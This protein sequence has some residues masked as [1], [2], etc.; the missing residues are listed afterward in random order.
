ML[1]TFYITNDDKVALAAEKAGVD[2]IFVDMEYI[3]K[4]K[5]QGNMNTV[6]NQH[7][8]DDIKII[9]S[10]LTTAKLLV[11]INPIHQN[12]EKE[13]EE[14]IA[15]GADYIMLPMWKSYEEV[16]EFISFVSCRVKTVLLLETDEARC[17]LDSVLTINGIDEI[18]IGLN[19][20]HLSQ[21]KKFMFQLLI[22][23]TIDEIADKLN[24]SK[25]SFGIGG[26]GQVGV[27]NLLP[28]ENILCE[29]YRLG[30]SMV[31]LARAFLDSAKIDDYDNFY[32]IFKSRL[33]ENK[34]Y[35]EYLSQ[36]DE[37]FFKEKHAQTALLIE[38]IVKKI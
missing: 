30:S 22:D 35:E 32:E 7:T 25:I 8:I 18:F 38:Q 4:N 13:I 33:Y 21:N 27:N 26:V 23:G 37:A 10:V 2:R 6:K 20:L 3:D 31:I 5:R 15:A 28:A 29:H 24:K 9:K 16:Y 1:K 14:V 17:C 34:K 11:R 36:R 19:D 12:S